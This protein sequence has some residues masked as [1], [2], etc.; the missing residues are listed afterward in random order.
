MLDKGPSLRLTRSAGNGKKFE[1]EI[2]A[3]L[4]RW[5]LIATVV[6]MLL[7]RG[8]DPANILRILMKPDPI[9]HSCGTADR[10]KAD[11]NHSLRS[12][13]S[14]YPSQP[15]VRLKDALLPAVRR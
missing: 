8:A 12:R 13:P 3:S 7:A 4:L 1:L 9:C 14:T 15:T 2:R 5:L 10:P 11:G 6:I